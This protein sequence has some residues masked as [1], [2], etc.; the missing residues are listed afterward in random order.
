[1]KTE[2]PQGRVLGSILYLI[3]INNIGIV[4]KSCKGFSYAD[5]TVLY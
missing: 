5:D 1:M 3:Y 2:I 4:S